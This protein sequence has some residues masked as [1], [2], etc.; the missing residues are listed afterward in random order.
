MGAQFSMS[1][2]TYE[3]LGNGFVETSMAT[4]TREIYT[5]S[6]GDR[7][8][9]GSESESGRVFVKHE[10]NIPSGGHVTEFDI[11]AF[12]RSH[13]GSPEHQALMHLVRVHRA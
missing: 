4:K 9:V 11:D 8:L 6:N 1:P 13:G 2:D 7:W 10:A 12:L 3:A 5:S